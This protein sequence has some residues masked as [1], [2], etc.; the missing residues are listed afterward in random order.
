MIEIILISTDSKQTEKIRLGKHALKHK[1][2]GK[3]LVVSKHL[4]HTCKNR[5]REDISAKDVTFQAQKDWFKTL[6]R[7]H[8]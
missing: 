2:L 6:E 3:G 5:A 8:L 7:H 1:K 4:S